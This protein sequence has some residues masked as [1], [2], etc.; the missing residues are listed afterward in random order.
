MMRK[1][2][3]GMHTY[4]LHLWGFGQTWFS[5]SHEKVFGLMELMD[6]A[7][8]W[9]LDGLHITPRDLEHLDDPW[10]EKIAQGAKERGLYLELN[11]ARDCECDAM[12]NIPLKQ[13]A[14]ISHKIGAD[15][16][17][18]SMDIR[19]KPPLYGSS[20]QATVMRQLADIH[21]DILEALPEFEKYGV[22]L[23]VENHTETFA[24]EVLWLVNA[25]DHP[26]VKTCVDTVNSMGVLEGPEIAIAK[27]APLAI[28]C[29]FCDH[30]WD[31]DSYGAR[32]HGMALGEG[33]MNCPKMLDQLRRDAPLLHR[34]NFEIEYDQGDDS[35]EVAREKQMDACIRS[36]TYCRD[37]L[38]IGREDERI[39]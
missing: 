6:K 24:D 11:F 4:T 17:K 25:I 21:D 37:V 16:A 39:A 5:Q 32:F 26:L 28:C 15:I 18:Y 19:R 22:S 13:A 33:D 31:R 3:L 10:L 36:I 9:G 20:M 12:I 30:K 27:L 14:Y 7:R 8:E 34:I 23:A 1:M 38:Q 2:Q 29:H 35:L